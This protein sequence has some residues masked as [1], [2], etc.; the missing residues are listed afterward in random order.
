VKNDEKLV[1]D[2]DISYL[3]RLANYRN[4]N[5]LKKE[6]V[7]TILNSMKCGRIIRGF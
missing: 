6:I 2:V 7:T 1:G 3:G 5:K 4:P